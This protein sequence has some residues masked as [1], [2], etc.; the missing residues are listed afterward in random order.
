MATE[1]IRIKRLIWLYFLL[2]IFEGALRKWVV[3][4]LSSPL[5]IIRDPLVI[6]IY[7]IAFKSKRFPKDIF[8]QATIGLAFISLLG[9]LLT[10]IDEQT[11]LFVTFFGIRTNFLH[12]PLIFLICK[13]FNL[14]DVKKVGKWV[15]LIAI[16]MAILMVVQFN[17]PPD[18][19][20]NRTAGVGEGQQIS[21]A[22]GKIRTP[23]TFSFISGAGQYLCM[24]ASFLLYGL[25]EKKVYPNWLLLAAGFSLVLGIAVSGSR[26]TILSVVIVF[27]SLLIILLVRPA[28]VGSSYKFLVLLGVVG[29]G[30]TFIP[31]FSQGMEVIDSRVQNASASESSHG[32]IFGRISH[33][34]LRVFGQIDD[35]PLLGYGPGMGTNVGAALLTGKTQFLLA[36]EEWQRVVLESGPV[37]G[38]LYVL[39]RISIVSWMGWI[40]VKNANIGNILPLL[41][42][43]A[44]G[45]LLLNGQFSRSSDIGFA[46]LITGLCLASTK[47]LVN[48][49]KQANE[50]FTGG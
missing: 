47:Y 26:Y 42:F 15:L 10:V 9:G 18:A 16:P 35:V 41:L 31:T 6:W 39:L 32:G 24:V 7:F 14:E 13:V 19:F 33:N 43:S 48:N 30:I 29:F 1:T 25:F 44:G 38:M 4:Q 46:V 37:L 2:L 3:P 17:S 45:I 8:T 34:I 49:S 21:S 11:N 20:I 22:L 23:G 27:M 5:L 12:L 50:N 36:E 40:C 28:I